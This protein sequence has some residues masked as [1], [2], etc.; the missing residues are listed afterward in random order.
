MCIYIIMV[1]LIT[2]IV[3]DHLMITDY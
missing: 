2:V 1:F 3:P